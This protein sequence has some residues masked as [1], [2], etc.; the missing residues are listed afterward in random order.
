M[1]TGEKIEQVVKQVV[2]AIGRDLEPGTRLIELKDPNTFEEAYQKSIAPMS[3]TDSSPSEDM[4]AV[5]TPIVSR[6]DI[7]LFAVETNRGDSYSKLIA[8]LDTKTNEL[9]ILGT[10][11]GL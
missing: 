8:Y 1:K 10:R 7:R 4:A 2:H 3:W 6:N 11:V 5:L 9:V